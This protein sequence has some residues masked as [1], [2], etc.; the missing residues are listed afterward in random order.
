[1]TT[2]VHTTTFDHRLTAEARDR[3]AESA[4]PLSVEQRRLWLLMDISSDIHPVVVGRYRAP[5]PVSTARAQMAL[6][7]AVQR[8]EAL[9]SVF[10][11]VQGRPV[12]FVLPTADIDL[13][14]VESSGGTAP[15]EVEEQVVQAPFA[16]GHGP[17]L[18]VLLI[19]R[20]DGTELLLAGH[21]LVLDDTSLEIL[22]ADLLGTRTAEADQRPPAP[23]LGTVLARQ[24]R[25]LAD[26]RLNT[27]VREWGRTLAQPAATEATDRPRPPV[28]GH[29]RATRNW[30]LPPAHT[31]D[32]KNTPSLDQAA[33][34][35]LTLLMRFHGSD[36]AVCGLHL[37]RTADH[38]VV[39]PLDTLLPVRCDIGPDTTLAQIAQDVRTQME[40]DTAAVPFA[41][42]IEARPPRR[43][44]S[45]TPYLRTA[46]RAVRTGRNGGERP[47]ALPSEHPATEHDLLVTL[48][49]GPDALH[50]QLDYDTDVLGADM[51]GVIADAFSHL[52]R[53]PGTVP[54]TAVPL[55]ADEDLPGLASAGRAS[56]TAGEAV[57]LIDL[58]AAAVRR[59]PDAPALDSGP[60]TLD[61]ASLWHRA[62]RL[63]AGL[64]ARGVRPRDRVAVLAQ[65][66]PDAAALILGV[67]RA[68]AAVIPIDPR[69]P[70]E[71]IAWML[72]DSAPALV[73][74]DIPPPRSGGVAPEFVTAAEL[75]AV[76]AQPPGD[77]VPPQDPAYLIYTSGSTGRP[78]GVVVEHASV[79]NNIR[80]RQ[81]LW[82]LSAADTVLH[83]HPFA[84]DPAM[85]ALLWP[86]T[87]GAR[88]VLAPDGTLE[89]TAEL[90]RMVA[91]HGVTVLGGIPSLLK[92]L[93]GALAA[94]RSTRV[95]LVMSGGEPLN[96]D[97]V[98]EVRRLWSAEV[99]NL[100]GPTETT[101]DATGHRVGPGTELPAALPIGTPV[102]STE[103]HI[104]DPELRPLPPGFAG[105]IVVGGAGV[106]RGYHA[107]PGPTAAR[108]VPNPW[109]PTPGARL[110]RTG[111]L[112]RRRT[113][114]AVEFIGR[115]DLQVK[116][117]GHRIELS[118]VSHALNGAPGV[119]E[120]A[121]FAIDPGTDHARLGAAAVA[122]ERTAAQIRAHLEREL[123]RSLVPDRIDVLDALPRTTN[124]KIDEEALIRGVREAEARPAQ[125]A[126]TATA[127]RSGLERSVAAGF[128]TVLRLD[129]TDVNADFFELGGT[130]LLLARLAGILSERHGVQIP[131]HEFFRVP[132]VAAVA[133]TI[134]LYRSEGLAAV[135][136]RQHAEA[137]EAD[138][139]LPETVT[140]AGLE[141]ANWADPR[142][143]LLTGATGYLGLHL[144]EQLLRTT[145]AEIVC[146]CRA[147]D[148]E[149]AM[150]RLREGM[151]Q[152]EIDI[153]DLSRVTCLVGD[154]G[155]ERFGLGQREW[156][157][158]CATVDVIHHNG[159]LVNFVYP[160]SV[161]RE[162]NVEGTRRILELA[163]TT[164]LKAVHYVST[165][166]TLLAT[167]SPRPFLEDDAPL[168]SAVGVPMG[169]TGSKWVAEK[170]VDTARRRG[171]PTTVFRPGLI[172]GHT[173]NG[174]TQTIDYL[175]VA[176]RGYLPMGIIPD[177]PRIFDIIPVDYTA[178]A[179][180]HI[181]LRPD[182]IGGFYH[183]FNPD[184]VPL[185]TFCGWVADY[186]YSFDIVPFETG[187]ERA[188][189]VGP[190][191]PL[192]PLVPL[193]RDAEA[194]PHRALDPRYIHEVRPDLECAQTLK[195]L[196]GSGI[197]CPPTRRQDAHA[198]LDY[199]VRTGFMNAPA[200]LRDE[201]GGTLP[202]PKEPAP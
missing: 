149:H 68:G 51:A 48:W 86:L 34:A 102:D 14:V 16:V 78:K 96:A 4:T 49:D 58:I 10:A 159:A 143:V 174:A 83:N 191:H 13:R 107:S 151:E 30:T 178:R 116:I 47:R 66:T 196:E 28:K 119:A 112:G 61:Y 100:Y 139:A 155:L 199:L 142:V 94:E 82:K 31:E 99:V 180:T 166:D 140:P 39:G 54:A 64:R 185:S 154:L 52:L 187:R 25:A 164:R 69:H 138:A 152:Y 98:S 85:W 33:A 130:S 75:A 161:L 150:R 126:E 43:D 11:P 131:V 122:P 124:G 132:T 55:S 90:A 168:R 36:A 19:H 76:D 93:A 22:A 1:M 118:E 115:V 194:E 101:I 160:Y 184:P 141:P 144:L 134:E 57:S 95:R 26:D 190:E 157:E 145:S 63:A 163:C 105:E 117:R 171:V 153:P 20:D 72:A 74:G 181:S 128:S 88:I 92:A 137:L 120:A 192:Y 183:L 189:R 8:N 173:R 71:R 62:G 44:L 46:V 133:E 201:S 81:R 42:L 104:V 193:I 146:L 15:Q 65:R 114:G 136:G 17:L 177:Y 2:S 91:A 158:L 59:T 113:D 80:W 6:A 170:M 182:A 111:D 175:L 165:I 186:G 70:A 202:T 9:R 35:W 79:A 73:A 103:V 38:G 125:A 169:Y 7:A 156:D 197:V 24:R 23:S 5:G 200:H 135:L 45:R 21:R 87:Q 110:Y 53:Q 147:R 50:L 198:V 37:P 167:H 129:V 60:T 41:H 106:A 108:F 109:S 97:L 40:A 123:P 77:P 188:L 195:M 89:D 121:V 84:F 3:G 176:L 179:I 12:R 18:R 148:P 162:P 67:M 127:P 29:R 27:A 56:A 32:G 172:L